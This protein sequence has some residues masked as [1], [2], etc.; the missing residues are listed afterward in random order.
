MLFD[1]DFVEAVG[2]IYDPRMGTEHVATLLYSLI[3]GARPRRVLE[4]GMGYTS[5]FILKALADNV[6]DFDRERA[7]VD[8]AVK[9]NPVGHR[10]EVE[11]LPFVEFD[12]YRTPYRP[13]LHAIDALVHPHSGADKV[14]EAAR[15]LGL[16]EYLRFHQADFRGCS[17][18]LE[19][20]D[21]P[22]DFIWLDAGGYA[23]YTAFAAEYWDLLNPDG[24][25][26]LIH[27]TLT[28]LEA[29]AYVRELK[30]RQA[31]NAFHDFELVS[32]LEPHKVAQNSFTLI[33][34]TSGYTERLYTMK[35]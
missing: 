16:D 25:L 2:K 31:T 15:G 5:C 10:P 26:W 23:S 34:K 14:M 12:H 9:G 1:K 8:E 21:L 28:N 11:G 30:L 19:D 27:S 33:R 18:R 4:V 29:I 35:P 6:A 22:L 13:A 24:G 7:A 17:Q 20:E 32:V 3:R